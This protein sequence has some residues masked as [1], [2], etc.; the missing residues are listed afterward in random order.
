MCHTAR[1]TS[2]WYLHTHKEDRV[3][4]VEDICEM[5]EADYIQGFA[6]RGSHAGAKLSGSNME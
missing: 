5:I 2:N 4:M 3:L 6:D 1:T